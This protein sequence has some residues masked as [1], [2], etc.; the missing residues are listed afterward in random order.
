MSNEIVFNSGWK[1]VRSKDTHV[2]GC[3]LR[4][5]RAAIARA[6]GIE[7]MQGDALTWRPHLAPHLVGF[8]FSYPNCDH[9]SGNSEKQKAFVKSK[10]LESNQAIEPPPDLLRTYLQIATYCGAAPVAT[11]V[12]N[13]IEQQA[14]VD[15]TAEVVAA[16]S[17]AG[18]ECEVFWHEVTPGF[19][20]VAS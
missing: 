11:I 1:G 12:K 5:D 19:T 13:W 15:W 6:N 4:E 8:S 14:E 2:L 3:E 16:A 17:W 18:F 9:N 20:E 7:A 10:G